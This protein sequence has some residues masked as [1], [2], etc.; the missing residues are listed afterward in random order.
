MSRDGLCSLQ[1]KASSS[2]SLVQSS[3]SF[4]LKRRLTEADVVSLEFQRNRALLKDESVHYQ[5]EVYLYN[6]CKV[7]AF[8]FFQKSIRDSE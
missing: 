3:F 2:K 7:A 4:G 5:A 1:V 6:L 8:E